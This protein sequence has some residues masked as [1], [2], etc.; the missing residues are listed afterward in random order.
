MT[1]GQTQPE[2]VNGEWM[3]P[4]VCSGNFTRVRDAHRRCFADRNLTVACGRAVLA[5]FRALSSSNG[6]KT[7]H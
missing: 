4:A 3:A 7:K 1:L 2:K 6:P 5:I